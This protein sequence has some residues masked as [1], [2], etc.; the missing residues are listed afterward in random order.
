[1]ILNHEANAKPMSSVRQLLDLQA[2]D[3]E[4]AKRN[5]RLG[6]IRE[7]LGNEGELPTLRV[8]AGELGTAVEGIEAR[9]SELDSAIADL[10]GRIAAV[11][12]KMYSGIVTSSRE[13]TDLQADAAMIGRRRS[14]SED[15]LLGVL[16]ELD[17]AQSELTETSERLERTETQW[18]EDQERIAEERTVLEAEVAVLGEKRAAQAATVP[19]PDL[20]TYERVRK[21]HAGYAVAHLR[22]ATCA[23]CR[24]GV[25]NKVAQTVRTSA[26]PVPCPSCGLLLLAD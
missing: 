21:T 8:R 7:Q 14:E 5:E 2:T 10:S 23:S 13:L 1:M 16:V 18:T 22:N 6:Q 26:S 20:A 11:E 9:Q 3:L 25:P 4:L 15:V 24:V 17:A 19:P 12:S